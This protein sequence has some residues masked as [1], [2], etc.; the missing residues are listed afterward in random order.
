MNN[1]NMLSIKITCVK[2]FKNKALY[3][4][5][6]DLM[7]YIEKLII[8]VIAMFVVYVSF[9]FSTTTSMNYYMDFGFQE[10]DKGYM[11]IPSYLSDYQKEEMLERLDTLAEEEHVIVYYTL[12]DH[13]N[14]NVYVT[15]HQ[16][17]TFFQNIQFN[18]SY[19]VG[20]K[21]NKEQFVYTYYD[22]QELKYDDLYGNIYIQCDDSTFL[23]QHSQDLLDIDSSLEIISIGHR[24]EDEQ[25]QVMYK[26]WMMESVIGLGILVLLYCVT[27]VF[28]I[29][30]NQRKV[31][32]YKLNGLSL[33]EM[34]KEILL[35]R[36]VIFVLI[37]FIVVVLGYL[38]VG[39]NGI[40]LSEY[41]YWFVI[42]YVLLIVLIGIVDIICCVIVGRMHILEGIM[43]KYSHR[44]IFAL[45]YILKSVFVLLASVFLF[46]SIQSLMELINEY[47]LS[48]RLLE[49]VASKVKIE[50]FSNQIG[51]TIE[52]IMAFH[53]KVLEALKDDQNTIYIDASQYDQRN[54]DLIDENNPY[55]IT[56][57]LKESIRVNRTYLEVQDIVDVEGN[58]ASDYIIDDE[59]CYLFV[60]SSLMESFELQQALHSSYFENYQVI[61]I[62]DHQLC[63][64]Y[65]PGYIE[66]EGGFITDNYIIVDQFD[67][68]HCLIEVNNED[69][70]KG[71]E[72]WCKNY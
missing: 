23:K 62:E 13:T 46:M 8:V 28:D 70:E 45:D 68:Y 18:Q 21:Y 58:Q 40:L 51:G 54:Q 50:S 39:N 55:D 67:I 6:G 15:Y 61:E 64:T 63:F 30:R 11:N 53:D 72:R 56:S 66:S 27:V 48:E 2:L 24:T 14:R 49:S 65:Q 36:M 7:K 37:S 3:S 32:V 41:I 5:R 60:P 59:G 35:G 16:D 57:Y 17:E 1:Q 9:Q 38:L 71:F 20:T 10:V 12:Y 19:Y 47:Q 34:M 26:E 42:T 25:S 31:A 44:L 43:N 33:F 69:L 4:K 52:E 29:V 22:L